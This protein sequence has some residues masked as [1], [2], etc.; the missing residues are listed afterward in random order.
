[1]PFDLGC[2]KI[3]TCDCDFDGSYS[4]SAS[5]NVTYIDPNTGTYTESRDSGNCDLPQ[6]PGCFNPP[7]TP[8]S[9]TFFLYS[10]FPL[11]NS[12]GFNNEI[13]ITA[14]A[15]SGWAE[16]CFDYS[17][18]CGIIPD[19]TGVPD[20]SAINDR[21]FKDPGY[22]VVAECVV[23][24]PDNP[25]CVPY[26]SVPAAYIPIYREYG[27]FGP[28]CE[29]DTG[30]PSNEGPRIIAAG[31][32]LSTYV[33]KLNQ[34]SG[35]KYVAT[36]L[37]PDSYWIGGKR[38][39]DNNIPGDVFTSAEYNTSF[40]PQGNKIIQREEMIVYFGSIL[41]SISVYYQGKPLPK[42]CNTTPSM[43]WGQSACGLA[44]PLEYACD[45]V[46]GPCEVIERN[47]V[48]TWRTLQ[49]FEENSNV[50]MVN[51]RCWIG[52]YSGVVCPEMYDDYDGSQTCTI[53]LT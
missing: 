52:V 48:T 38:S 45:P 46:P 17:A 2:N 49:Q 29:N 23:V 22:S 37:G 40:I 19:I 21:T 20:A 51:P 53:T 13:L 33:Q 28:G 41:H 32:R 35:G 39:L 8:G 24:D 36:Q 6:V 14:V 15:G 25:D 30:E 18:S 26:S 42:C 34:Y 11:I 31:C 27:D 50:T 9:P 47:V 5:Y 12:A 43:V 10:V 16:G 3:E 44:R 4:D 1:L 7:T